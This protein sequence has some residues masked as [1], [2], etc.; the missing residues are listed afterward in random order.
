MT[1][2]M[3][4]CHICAHT[5]AS[6]TVGVSSVFEQCIMYVCMHAVYHERATHQ[7]ASSCVGSMLYSKR[8]CARPGLQ[9][10]ERREEGRWARQDV[11]VLAG[12][13]GCS[14]RILACLRLCVWERIGSRTR[15]M[16]CY[17]WVQGFTFDVCVCVCVFNTCVP[18]ACMDYA[19]TCA[20]VRGQCV[21][22]ARFGGLQL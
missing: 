17:S 22:R 5:W 12:G 4:V 10:G 8:F 20:G 11:G 6:M 1:V 15:I 16:M 13:R 19:C 7:N 18:C 3:G 14:L 21:L 9:G 2:H